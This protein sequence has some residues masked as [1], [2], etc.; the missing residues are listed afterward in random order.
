MYRYDS[1]IAPKSQLVTVSAWNDSPLPSHKLTV[2]L[3]LRSQSDKSPWRP[4]DNDDEWLHDYILYFKHLPQ[5]HYIQHCNRSTTINDYTHLSTFVDR[6]MITVTGRRKSIG[7][8]ISWQWRWGGIWTNI[9]WLRCWRGSATWGTRWFSTD[10]GKPGVWSLSAAV[11]E[12]STGDGTAEVLSVISSDIS[13]SLPLP[14][15][16]EGSPREHLELLAVLVSFGFPYDKLSNVFTW[17]KQVSHIRS[18]VHTDY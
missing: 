17:Q 1:W 16:V 12:S 11:L 9:R 4:W 10:T 8:W 15:N 3:H 14:H 2:S 6:D 5:F 7:V 13:S 18:L